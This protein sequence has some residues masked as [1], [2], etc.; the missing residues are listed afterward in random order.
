MG[1]HK[2]YIDDNQVID[3]YRTSGCQA[4]IDWFTKGVDVVITSGDL[5]EH[6]YDLLN[7]GLL[8][9]MDKWNKISELISDASIKKGFE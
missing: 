8:T 9:D 3:I 5:S 1:F 4:V 6:V 7:I 2:R